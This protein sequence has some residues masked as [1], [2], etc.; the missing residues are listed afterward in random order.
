VVTGIPAGV[1]LVPETSATGTYGVE[2]DLVS[3]TRSGSTQTIIW[4]IV[5]SDSESISLNESIDFDIEVDYDTEDSD[6][7]L[8]G[9]AMA[10]GGFAP[11]STV[12]TA[13]STALEPRFIDSLSPSPAAEVFVIGPCRTILLFPYLTNAPGF[14]TGLAIS[15]TSSDPLGTMPQA[16]TCTLNFYGQSSGAKLTAAQAVQTTPVVPSGG[17]FLMLLSSNV[18]VALSPLNQD[19]V[20]ANASCASANCVLP[21]FQGYMFATC[22]FQFAHGFAFI[23]DLGASK[24]AMGYLALVVPD[25]ESRS[26]LPKHAG[27]A[28]PF[29]GN[30]QGEQLGN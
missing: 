5:T 28:L 11:V 20:V 16:G 6:A 12:T 14:D 7:N 4:E 23:S 17:Q 26:R 25:R 19:P 24:L 2:A 1:S 8:L 29:L 27:I 10:A 21:G 15:N 9:T 22:N 3:N 30:N 18:G 13:S